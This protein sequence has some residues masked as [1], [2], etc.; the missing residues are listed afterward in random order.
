MW[1]LVPAP[2][3]TQHPWAVLLLAASTLSTD[4]GAVCNSQPP[5]AGAVLLPRHLL[6]DLCCGKAGPQTFQTAPPTCAQCC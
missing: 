1:G 4:S 3:G 5:S 6:L 2:L